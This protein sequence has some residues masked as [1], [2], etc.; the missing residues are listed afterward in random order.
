MPQTDSFISANIDAENFS[1]LAKDIASNQ[2]LDDAI[3]MH[4]YEMMERFR[5]PDIPMNRYERRVAKA[6]Y[7]SLNKRRKRKR[8]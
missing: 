1:R 2:Q 3:Q 7:N 5:T 6:K 8:L 4:R